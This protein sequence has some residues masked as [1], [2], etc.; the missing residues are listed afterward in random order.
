MP[1]IPK[2]KPPQKS[3]GS[4]AWSAY[5][6][7]RLFSLWATAVETGCDERSVSC[8]SC[9]RWVGIVWDGKKTIAPGIHLHHEKK[10]LSH[11]ELKYDDTNVK[12]LCVE[13]HMEVHK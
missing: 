10:R 6:Q 9:G 7:R 13:C 2:P 12:V 5:R 1:S 8:S 4:K 11:P 3:K